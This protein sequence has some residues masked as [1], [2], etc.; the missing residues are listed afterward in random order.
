MDKTPLVKGRYNRPHQKK[1]A[2]K[3]LL[4]KVISVIIHIPQMG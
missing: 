1:R 4:L 3:L 2:A